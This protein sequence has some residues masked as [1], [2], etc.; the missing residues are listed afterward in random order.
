M[1]LLTVT[2]SIYVLLGILY[3]VVGIGA[4]LLPAGWISSRWVGDAAFL[5]DAATPESF[6][7][8]LTQEFGTLGIAVGLV[9]LWQARGAEPSPSLHWLLTFYLALDSLIHWVGPQGLIGSFRR[10]LINSIPPLL[11]LVLG[12]LRE[13]ANRPRG[14]S[15]RSGSSQSPWPTPPKG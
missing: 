11:L 14:A 5:Y 3:V 6:L 1:T 13:R 8:H 7:N 9:F 2:K 15:G 12:L 10:G 4:M